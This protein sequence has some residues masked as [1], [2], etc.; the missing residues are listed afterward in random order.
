MPRGVTS[1]AVPNI[2]GAE[3]RQVSKDV[4]TLY[5]PTRV[6]GRT[7]ADAHKKLE[8]FRKSV[9]FYDNN[10]DDEHELWITNEEGQ[11][12]M[13]SVVYSKGFETV[14]DD[15]KKGPNFY[16]IPLY[17]VASDPY[18]Y[19]PPGAEITR[20]FAQE[21]WTR[22][23]LT[24]TETK[25]ITQD[26]HVGDTTLKVADTVNCIPGKD[27]EIVG[28]KYHTTDQSLPEVQRRLKAGSSNL[29]SSI[30]SVSTDNG[31]PAVN[32]VFHVMG[33][34]VS[35]STGARVSGGAVQVTQSI[36]QTQ[37]CN[38]GTCTEQTSTNVA[39]NIVTTSSNGTYSVE[40]QGIVNGVLTIVV[41]FLGDAAHVGSIA[42]TSVTVG[43]ITATTL[44]L[45]CSANANPGINQAF[46]LSGTLKAG[47]TAL[48]G[49]KITLFKKSPSGYVTI[50][51][52]NTDKNGAY[53]FTQKVG[54]ACYMQYM[55]TYPGQTTTTGQGVL[56]P[57]WQW[58][59]QYYA[60]LFATAP[61]IY[62][63]LPATY[64]AATASLTVT[65]DTPTFPVEY[66]VALTPSM[67]NDGEIQYFC[68]PAASQNFRGVAC[69]AETTDD[70]Y[71]I[72]Q[73][74]IT[75]QGLYPV[76]DIGV[77]TRD[78]TQ[79]LSYWHT[80]LA[81]LASHGWLNIMNADNSGSQRT[82]A[83]DP[84]TYLAGL[85]FNYINTNP[86]PLTGSTLN[87]NP[88]ANSTHTHKNSFRCMNAASIPFIEN[89]INAAS[90]AH[91]P[92]GILAGVW[93]NDK[94][95]AN[96]ILANSIAN[97]CPDYHC[98]FDWSELNY[99]GMTNFI[100]WLH[101]NFAAAAG[102]PRHDEAEQVSLYKSLGFPMLVAQLQAHYPSSFTI[103]AA[104]PYTWLDPATHG[105]ARGVLLSME[106]TDVPLTFTGTLSNVVTGAGIAGETI[107][108]QILPRCELSANYSGG[109]TLHV[110]TTDG[111]AAGET[112]A[113]AGYSIVTSPATPVYNSETATI[114]GGGVNPAALT[115]TI[116][117][118]LTHTY[119][120]SITNPSGTWPALITEAAFKNWTD[121]SSHVPVTTSTAADG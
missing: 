88:D 61:A 76:I 113:I 111:F 91:K 70:Y 68:A 109:T 116:T 4:R 65:I 42:S 39:Q 45:S 11:T 98:M 108:L 21:P 64:G 34:V 77:V 15:E 49:K 1:D 101:P 22:N 103:D 54:M 23:F 7:P 31:N 16:V 79:P 81:G 35:S 71:T 62:G 46:T 84:A 27:I 107:N 44:T 36:T 52:A 3:L 2:A 37:V 82:G 69:I 87:Y 20:T 8:K 59:N 66:I 75:A 80:W 17:L 112:I 92:S 5:A 43:A 28:S 94:N 121:Q 32:E 100:V 63:G 51:T 10:S 78:T 14:A 38:N 114:A 40:V 58:F 60:D 99:T 30:I 13:C 90:A 119:A 115:I 55:V 29:T 57:F 33:S 117:A 118:P 89:S 104:G 48:T 53:S 6:V 86:L 25:E 50:T 105:G 9:V 97:V 56:S 24:H 106:Y 67:I 47:T 26:A 120:T 96:E 41:E 19:D 18:F 93:P 73:G 83:N 102:D 110:K 74:V 12:R 72:E 85:G 95:N